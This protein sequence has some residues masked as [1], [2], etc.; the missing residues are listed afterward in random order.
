MYKEI[1]EDIK[2]AI[3]NGGKTIE[4][5]KETGFDTWVVFVKE[6]KNVYYAYTVGEGN[7]DFIFDLMGF[8]K[9]NNCPIRIIT[10]ATL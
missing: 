10:M 7:K 4:I 1:L 9:Q 5:S 2:A 6:G 3:N 8:C